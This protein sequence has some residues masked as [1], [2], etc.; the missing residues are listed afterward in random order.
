MKRILVLAILVLATGCVSTFMTRVAA[1]S[2]P[3]LHDALA[4][5]ANPDNQDPQGMQCVIWIAT[6][7]PVIDKVLN[8][9]VSGALSAIAKRRSIENLREK[10]RPGFQNACAP[11]LMDERTR[12][13][14]YAGL[15]R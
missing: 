8:A 13:A 15:F 12:L 4:I 11:V 9:K 14:R 5:N 6:Q 1:I 2:K 7:Q 3:D 10:L